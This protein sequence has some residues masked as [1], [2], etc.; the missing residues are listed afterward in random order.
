MSVALP[1]HR[2]DGGL[3]E[4]FACIAAQ[5]DVDL[6]ILLVLNGA[7]APTARTARDLA[8]SDPRARVIELPGANLAAGLNEALRRA[9][10]ALVARMDAD[11]RCPPDRLARQAAAMHAAP[12][13]AALGTAYERVGPDG[14]RIDRVLPPTDPRETRWRLLLENVFCHGSMMLRRDAVLAVGGYDERCTRAQDYDL[15][16]RLARA[17]DLANLPD[18][19]YTYRVRDADAPS[20]NCAAQAAVAAGAPLDALAFLPDAPDPQA[21]RALRDALARQIAANAPDPDAIGALLTRDGPSREGIHAYLLAHWRRAGALHH[22]ADAGR[23]ACLRDVGRHMRDAGAREVTLWGA[24]AGAAWI[25][26]R[27]HDLALPI[28]AIV[29]DAPPDTT[30]HGLRVSRPDSLA[31]G[32]HVLIAS[33][34]F[35]DAIWR[36]SEPHRARGVHVWRLAPVRGPRA[37]AAR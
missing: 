11:D 9:R 27:Q 17:A 21:R 37:E 4:A 18:V 28:A 13:L 24:G 3:A 26:D 10:H 23:V 30:R 19:L 20:A 6:E 5:R 1:V 32:A 25:I 31:P 16:L 8:G 14:A 33:E 2:D 34:R 15:W 22:A 7:D 12:N 36:A 35:A 29:D